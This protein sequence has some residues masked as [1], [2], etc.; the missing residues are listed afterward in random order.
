MI[1][2]NDIVSRMASALDAENS[3]RYTFEEDYKPAINTSVEWV[4]TV[5]N[6]A[7]SENKLSEE[8]LQDL[9]KTV[10][11]QTSSLSRI[12][13]NAVN[14]NFSIWSILKVNPEP[15]IYPSGSVVTPTDPLVSIYRPDL[16][17][18]G[19]EYS[20]TRLTTEQW[21]SSQKNIF[22]PGN[23]RLLNSFKSY[24]YLPYS[25][26]QGGFSE[27]E[28][29]PN[30]PNQFVS[31]QLL[32]YPTPISLETDSVEY[33]KNLINLV[34]QKALNFISYKQGDQTNLYTVT[35]NDIGT[36]VSLMA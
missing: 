22:Q 32:K 4:Q 3:D 20:A 11:Y 19:S 24:S 30:I 2:V 25:E 23:E 21:E 33:P 14:L 26:Y 34:V 36:L 1:A 7:F 16:I 17:F 5:F 6:K 8:S 29:H 27:I 9:I 10:I 13:L 15:I 31:V 12:N 28:I 18:V 35:S